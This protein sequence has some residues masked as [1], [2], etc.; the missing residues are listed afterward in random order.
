MPVSA[1]PRIYEWVDDQGQHH[2]SDRKQEGARVLVVN[3]GNSYFVVEKV[4]DGDTILLGN[5]QKVRFLG[6]NTPEVAG[7]NKDAEVGGEKAKIWLKRRLEHKK[8]RLE[9]DA[10]KQDKYGRTLA[11]VFAE[12]KQHVNLELVRLGLAAV[13]IY[14]PNLKYV[15]TLLAAQ[16]SAER[17][18]LGI[19]QYKAYAPQHFESLTKRNYRGWKRVTGRVVGLKKTRK[20]SYLQF[21]DRVAVRIENKLLR[22]FP[23]LSS[24]VGKELEVRAWVIKQK[25][26]F[27]LPVRH[28][29]ELKLRGN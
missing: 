24:Y 21:S 25:D 17:E 9:F 29:G 26:R 5:G 18:G 15:D 19:W 16:Q 6:I 23:L 8:V 3:P 4:F 7:R 10:E 2:Y 20:Y 1:W 22:L 27:M 12:D 11:Y 13:N 14:P 28:P